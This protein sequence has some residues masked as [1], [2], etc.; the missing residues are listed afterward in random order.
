MLATLKT[1]LS[2]LRRMVHYGRLA[3]ANPFLRFAKP[4]HFYSPVPPPD[5]LLERPS[6]EARRAMTEVAG[7][8]LRADAQRALA[9]RLIARFGGLPDRGEN[10]RYRQNNQFFEFADAWSTYAMMR[11][12]QPR[13]VVEVGSGHSSALMLD[14][15]DADPAL[16]PRFTF[17]DPFPERLLA[18]LSAAD[19]ERS[20]I[21]V[22]RLQD[23]PLAVFTALEANDILFIDSSHVVRTG[24]DVDFAFR[25]ILPRLAPGVVIHIHDILWPFEY[26]EHWLKEGRAWNE[27]YFVRS[28]LQFNERFEILL[29]NA[30]LAH[31]HAD[32]FADTLPDFVARRGGSLWLRRVR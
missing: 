23:V 18:R 19:K 20:E 3:E 9:A 4:G 26:P 12:V 28:F 29:F 10:A 27:S 1:P 24:S 32:L 8:D 14:T 25:E 21:R 2:R 31:H 17:I 16:N 15:V 22:E 11:D 6:R 13:R 5:L 7:V 30:Y